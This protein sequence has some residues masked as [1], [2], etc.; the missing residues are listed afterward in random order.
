MPLENK[1]FEV[2]KRLRQFLVIFKHCDI[3]ETWF[4]ILLFMVWLV[5]FAFKNRLENHEIAVSKNPNF[6][7]SRLKTPT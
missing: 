2:K 5:H 3:L 4:S 1:I 6:A 7:S